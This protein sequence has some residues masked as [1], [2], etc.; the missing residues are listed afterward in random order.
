VALIGLGA[1]YPIAWDVFGDM[2]GHTNADSVT[3]TVTLPDGTEVT[4]PVQNPPAETGKYR[5]AYQTTMPG[6][7]TAHAVT[8]GPVT[9]YD[10]EWDVSE[11]PWMAIVSLADAKKQLGIDLDDHR[12]DDLLRDYLAGITGAIEE[13]KHEKIPRQLVP[14][15]IEVCRAWRF[16]LWSA[17]VLSLVS[18][19]SWDGSLTWD[20]SN[21]RPRPSGVVR[22]MAGPP[23]TGLV[24]VAYL[25]GYQV[26][27]ARYKRGSL[28]VLE[29]VWETQRGAGTVMSGVVGPE[30]RYRQPGEWFTVPNKAKEWL[31]PPRPVVA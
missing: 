9:V 7:H 6:R 18:V 27:P 25:A 23:V 29:H 22:V 3:L 21:M 26:I 8:S 1:V 13:Y 12:D 11:T 20:V 10:D 5:L 24:D 14:D 17:P 15:E 2:G 30:E 16:R 31:G 28:I 4:P 19:T